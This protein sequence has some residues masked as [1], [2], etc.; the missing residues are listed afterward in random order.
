V[1]TEFHWWLVVVGL[2]I[3]GGLVWIVLADSRR[4]EEDIEARELGPEAAW[5]R[6]TLADGGR[7]VDQDVVEA[8]LLLHREYRA[9]PPPDEIEEELEPFEPDLREPEPGAGGRVASPRGLE[10]PGERRPTG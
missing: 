3:G 6:E 9:A 4:R 1:N 7:A 5:I 8:V 10:T 2:I